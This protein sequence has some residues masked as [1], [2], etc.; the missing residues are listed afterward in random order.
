MGGREKLQAGGALDAIKDKAVQA[1]DKVKGA[2]V[3]K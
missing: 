3:V 1:T 2:V